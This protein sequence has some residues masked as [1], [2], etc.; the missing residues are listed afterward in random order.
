MQSAWLGREQK[1]RHD[2][3][4][5]EAERDGVNEREG[6]MSGK[7]QSKQ[8]SRKKKKSRSLK[9][10][11]LSSPVVVLFLI[12]CSKDSCIPLRCPSPQSIWNTLGPIAQRGFNAGSRKLPTSRLSGSRQTA[13][14]RLTKYYRTHPWYQIHCRSHQGAGTA[15]V[16]GTLGSR[17][18]R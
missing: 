18:G 16:S 14:P 9:L 4:K 15:A 10:V 1:K 3:G 13:S 8:K 5:R 17:I 7:N 6:R 12:C 11:G 2:F